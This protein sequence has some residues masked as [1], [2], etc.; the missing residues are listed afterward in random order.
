MGRLRRALGESSFR[1]V[2]GGYSLC[3][4]RLDLSRRGGTVGHVN[5]SEFALVSTANPRFTR[6]SATIVYP[7]DIPKAIA[8]LDAGRDLRKRSQ[9]ERPCRF[10]QAENAANRAN[11]SSLLWK[12]A[13][14]RHDDKYGAMTPATATSLLDGIEPDA[15]HT[16]KPWFL[17]RDR[18]RP[19]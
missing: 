19:H 8:H 5:I 15:G 18:Y 17:R 1:L 13:F 14:A 10:D 3:S 11:C 16:M 4:V 7:D 12:I 2:F 9:W 6:R